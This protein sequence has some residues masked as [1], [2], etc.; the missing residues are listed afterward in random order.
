MSG[1]KDEIPAWSGDPAEFE[2]YATACRWYQRSLKDS[3]RKLVVARLWGRLQGAAKSV[4]RHLDPDAYDDE[5]GLAR[6]LNVL[7]ASPLQQLPVPD[8]FS[9]L[10]RWNT[11]RRRDRESVSELIVREEEVF[12]ELQQALIRA[13]QDRN[14]SS[15]ISTADD[16]RQEAGD[17][18]EA[19]PP[20]TPSR[21]PLHPQRR[22]NEP[23]SSPGAPS[24]PSEADFFSDEL[25]GYRLLRA[26][27][28]TQQEKQNV[29]V[30]TS[31]STSFVAIRRSLRTLF[32]EDF[33]K[34]AIKTGKVWWHD[35]EWAEWDDD[36]HEQYWHDDGSW[37]DQSPGS[38][39]TGWDNS[40]G[41]TGKTG[42]RIGRTIG[43]TMHGTQQ[44][45]QPKT[46]FQMSR[47]QILLRHSFVRRMLWQ[48]K[49]RRR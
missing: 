21:S 3:D 30:Q 41:C 8:S 42:L 5:S 13:R 31:N 10:D 16:I 48:V 23:D 37:Y 22:R 14:M 35:D 38:D 44:L 34:Q 47:Q 33:D 19:N 18:D 4:V 36:S 11:L 29:L 7:R 28:L 46:L 40:N 20:S 2:T 12:T 43:M 24:S 26:C 9:R 45:I 32:A 15:F 1:P 39:T 17:E 25:R 6:F 49:H 27:R